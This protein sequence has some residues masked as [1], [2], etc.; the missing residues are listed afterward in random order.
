MPDSSWLVS[1]TRESV[2]LSILRRYMMIF[3]TKMAEAGVLAIR[4]AMPIKVAHLQQTSMLSMHTAPMHLS[5]FASALAA[6]YKTCDVD[7]AMH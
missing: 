2:S 1:F 5:S 6:T 3:L 7:T 4:I